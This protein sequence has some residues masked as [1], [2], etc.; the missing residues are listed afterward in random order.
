M[1]MK[2]PI[3]QIIAAALVL[4]GA[5]PVSSA[6]SQS[7]ENQDYY[8]YLKLDW[9]H[10]RYK[11]EIKGT[12]RVEPEL[13][14]GGPE[15][16]WT[17]N[18]VYTGYSFMSKI[19]DL[20]SYNAMPYQQMTIN[21]V[22]KRTSDP[23]CEE[24]TVETET[25]NYKGGGRDKVESNSLTLLE[26][27]GWSRLG[28]PPPDWPVNKFVGH[29]VAFAIDYSPFTLKLGLPDK[30]EPRLLVYAKETVYQPKGVVKREPPQIK[31]DAFNFRIPNVPDWIVSTKFGNGAVRREKKP[32]PKLVNG[33]FE[34]DSGEI[35]IKETLLEGIDTSNKATARITYTLTPAGC[36]P[37][38]LTGGCGE[39]ILRMMRKD[40]KW[41]Y[42]DE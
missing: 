20:L 12:G 25:W 21:D 10:L 33:S 13:G 37:T 29:S 38:P 32:I 23:T 6:F 30:Y 26:A 28:A 3:R 19:P 15:I 41:V 34:V 9:W 2:D 31:P 35:P 39:L 36:K 7:P 17:V 11:V 1:R 16:E 5:F 40:G 18:R 8:A 4:A 27:P 14:S 24:Y 22:V 42:L